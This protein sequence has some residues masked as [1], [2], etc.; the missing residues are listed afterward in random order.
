[1]KK[2]PTLTSSPLSL[3]VKPLNE[4]ENLKRNQLIGQIRIVNINR[5]SQKEGLGISIT[6]GR[7]HGVPILISE[8]HNDGP[9]ARSNELYVGDAILAVNDID[10]KD[11]L[12][13][14]AVEVLSNL[15]IRNLI[16]W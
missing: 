11:A 1:M 13:S 4:Q 6:G 3:D 15:V 10:L 9:A 7:E 2:S 8:I 16:I 14:D 12:H 5:K